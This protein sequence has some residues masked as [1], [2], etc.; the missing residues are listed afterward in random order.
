MLKKFLGI[1]LL[2]LLVIFLLIG[3]KDSVLIVCYAA[4]FIYNAELAIINL[5]QKNFRLSGFYLALTAGF[6]YLF[7]S[8]LF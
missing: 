6:L 1:S 4:I 5:R 8:T 2:V 7:I 3:K